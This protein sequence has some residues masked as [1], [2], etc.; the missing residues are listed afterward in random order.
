MTAAD[1]AK[2]GMRRWCPWCG[3]IEPTSVKDVRTRK[4]G[5][6]SRRI[7]CRSCGERFRTIEIHPGPGYRVRGAN[8]L[9]V[10]KM[11]PHEVRRRLADSCANLPVAPESIERQVDGLMETLWPSG[12]D[13]PVDVAEVDERIEKALLRL[14]PVAQVRYA[15]ATRNVSTAAGCMDVLAEHMRVVG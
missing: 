3:T 11:P 6:V 10:G 12:T 13:E 5:V 1:E 8:G 4:S 9:I 7:E 2:T 14:H 15:L